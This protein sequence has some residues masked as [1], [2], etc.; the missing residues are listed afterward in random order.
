MTTV[1][2]VL[3]LVVVLVVI[4]E[5]AR[6]QGEIRRVRFH[7]NGEPIDGS[8]L[9]LDH[10]S[11]IQKR[12]NEKDR[13]LDGLV[14]VFLHGHAQRQ[15]DGRI[16][17]EALAERSKSR[18]IVIPVVFTPFGRD[19]RWR[20]DAGKVVLLMEL[21][22]IALQNERICVDRFQPIEEAPEVE[23]SAPLM[24]PEKSSEL[25]PAELMA[26]GWSHGGILARR[27]ASSYPESVRKLAL[28][29]P[30]GHHNWGG[31]ISGTVRLLIAFTAESIRIG[32]GV[33]KGDAQDVLAAG[34]GVLKGI[35]G[36]GVGSVV[37]FLLGNKHPAKLFRATF[38]AYQTTTYLTSSNAPVGHLTHLV[39]CFA[40][41][42]TAFPLASAIDL[43]L[44]GR[45][46]AEVSE[47][48]FR[49]LYARAGESETRR[50]LHHLPSNHLAPILAWETY[51]ETVL[52]ETEERRE[53][54]AD[55]E[56]A[57]GGG[58]RTISGVNP[59]DQCHLTRRG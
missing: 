9:L 3:I 55:D 38:D 25:I 31:T 21:T 35:I 33:F 39:I 59:V 1:V 44:D 58:E 17:T 57:I 2:L 28:V 11:E 5:S 6:G 43:P 18:I 20:G 4:Y 12:A 7:F 26:V 52:H 56:Q 49:K 50:S 23:R 41:S 15:S 8:Y 51:A 54:P 47:R 36:D 40:E 13:R 14:T 32:L 45:V 10:R 16:F 37:S 27:F 24:N 34:W 29:T 30:A 46:T 22:R 42:D 53:A 19:K 48:F